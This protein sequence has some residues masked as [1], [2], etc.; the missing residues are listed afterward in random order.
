MQGLWCWSHLLKGTAIPIL[1][2]TDHN[3][4]HNL[5]YY[6]DLWKIGPQVTGYLLE[7]EQYNI[8]LEYK[9][10][11]TNQANTLSRWPDY[12]GKNPA[13]EDIT[14]WPDQYFC[15]N[16]TSIWVFDMNS[17]GDNL[18][19]KV[20]KAQN[21]N[22]SKLKEGASLHNLSLLDST[23]WHHRTTLVVVADNE[24]RREVTSLFHDHKTV[25]HPGITK[26][27]QLISPYY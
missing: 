13:N 3:N 26:T 4:L 24:L 25:G 19:Q 18:D 1:V 9:P 17:I 6:R 22:Q 11:A 23:H 15:N 27:L 12:E 21:R 16:H 5:H 2:F 10:G 7:W 14:I 8:I 20:K